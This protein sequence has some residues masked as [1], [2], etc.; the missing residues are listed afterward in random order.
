M[1]GDFGVLQPAQTW[2]ASNIAFDRVLRTLKKINNVILIGI[3]HWTNERQRHE[4]EITIKYLK[5]VI[6]GFFDA[7]EAV[8]QHFVPF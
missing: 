7:I 1:F 8:S 5:D 2:L 4:L 6:L 3:P